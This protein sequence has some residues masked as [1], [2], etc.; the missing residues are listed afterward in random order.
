MQFLLCR[1]VF[2]V[3]VAYTSCANNLTTF[4]NIWGLQLIFQDF[5][6]NYFY[7]ATG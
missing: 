4:V 1:R 2:Q 3:V 5:I 6:E 7:K